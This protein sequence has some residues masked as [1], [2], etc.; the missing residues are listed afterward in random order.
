[1]E[2][3]SGDWGF[4]KLNMIRMEH[5]ERIVYLFLSWV[6]GVWCRG[7]KEIRI[8]GSPAPVVHNYGVASCLSSI[9]H[10]NRIAKIELRSCHVRH[11]CLH[12]SS[13]L[14]RWSSAG[15]YSGRLP[16]DLRQP[17]GVSWRRCAWI[18]FK[19]TMVAWCCGELWFQDL[20]TTRSLI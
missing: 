5:Y 6:M 7:L 15:T 20:N 13:A 19:S 8:I 11:A 9:L 18:V 2:L 10:H 1:M 17:F 16:K 4:L 12:Y 3:W 14:L